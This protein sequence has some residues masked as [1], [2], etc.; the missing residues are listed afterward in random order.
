MS[1]HLYIL[2]H[3]KAE[4]LATRDYDRA[5]AP[6]GIAE[7]QALAKR[8]KPPGTA[9][10]ALISSAVRTRQTADC[11]LTGWGLENWP[12][13]RLEEHGYLAPARFWLDCLVELPKGTESVYI[14]GHNPG[15]SDLIDVLVGNASAPAYLRTSEGVHLIM[16]LPEWKYL[17]TGTAT[18]RETYLR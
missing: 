16:D 6:R 15:V 11:L 12:A 5:L 13:V 1:L 14:I 7:A 2:R 3:G 4:P 10:L 8:M 9:D 17:A 18:V